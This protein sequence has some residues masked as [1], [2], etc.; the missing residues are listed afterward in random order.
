M[1]ALLHRFISVLKILVQKCFLGS[2]SGQETTVLRHF[3][4]AQIK[5]VTN[6]RKSRT[7]AFF[8]RKIPKE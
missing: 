4:S 7:V 3:S 2:C 8:N 5:L 6:K 1:N